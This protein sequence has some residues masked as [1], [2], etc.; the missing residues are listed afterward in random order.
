[1]SNARDCNT[2]FLTG[3]LFFTVI[4]WP[5]RGL[6][7]RVAQDFPASGFLSDPNVSCKPPDCDY[8][9]DNED[10]A[11]VVGEL[12]ITVTPEPDTRKV[13]VN[14]SIACSGEGSSEVVRG[15]GF[16][17]P[18]NSMAEIF[19]SIDP[20]DVKKKKIDGYL[21]FQEEDDR[22]YKYETCESFIEKF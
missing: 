8:Y 10:K 22:Y 17:G 7:E 14:F 5:S 12:K 3:L 15:E 21:Q 4:A 19:L 18:K 13:D 1:M 11:T 6:C 20:E 9:E 2:F 16:A